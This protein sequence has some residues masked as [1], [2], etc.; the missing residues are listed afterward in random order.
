MRA[1]ASRSRSGPSGRAESRPTSP[2]SAR[3]RISRP[4]GRT[5]VVP[6]CSGYLDDRRCTRRDGRPV[7]RRVLPDLG[8]QARKTVTDVSGTGFRLFR[9]AQVPNH[10]PKV[11]ALK[12][13]PHHQSTQRC[14][15]CTVLVLVLTCTVTRYCA[16]Y[17]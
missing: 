15:S 11:R 8:E 3:G 10:V 1:S 7:W 5:G 16:E 13:S 14:G 4:C 9:G 12:I 17:T 6:S 2:P